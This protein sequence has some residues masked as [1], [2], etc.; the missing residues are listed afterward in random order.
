MVAQQMFTLRFYM[1]P[2]EPMPIISNQYVGVIYNGRSYKGLTS[3][4]TV[5]EQNFDLQG[6]SVS[7]FD[8]FTTKGVVISK[9]DKL[10][11]CQLKKLKIY[12][13]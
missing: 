4:I 3:S 13:P 10:V 1:T 5:S 7:V 11:I 8:Y 12:L 9:N 6:K 2:L